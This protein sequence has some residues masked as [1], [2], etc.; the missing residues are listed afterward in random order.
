MIEVEGLTKCYGGKPVVHGLDL[1]I[2]T[3]SVYGLLG[4]NGAGTSTT[5]RMLTGMVQPDSGEAELLGESIADLSPE[6]Q[7]RIG[8]IA[9]G[10]PLYGGM[11]ISSAFISVS[12]SERICCRNAPLP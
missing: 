9:E 10:H 3:G 12:I 8:C 1:S 6:T 7:Q 11:T 2:P 5:I 4:R